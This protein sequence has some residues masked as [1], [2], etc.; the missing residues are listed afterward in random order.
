MNPKMVLA[1]VHT[2]G[3]ERPN[4]TQ[5]MSGAVLV[6]ML[7]LALGGC[8]TTTPIHKMEED[9][10]ASADLAVNTQQ[11]R[12][13][14]RALV[15]PLSAVIVTNADRIRETA[16]NRDVQREALLFKIQAVLRPARGAL[17]PGSIQRHPRLLGVDPA[18]ERLF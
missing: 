14:M 17:S 18:D 4:N 5:V 12:V 16:P 2:G 6:V 3:R 15:E 9:V 13:R 7:L 10:H 8:L 1:L 11:I